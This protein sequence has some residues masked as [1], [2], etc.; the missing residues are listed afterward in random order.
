MDGEDDPIELWNAARRGDTDH[1]LELLHTH[2]GPGGGHGADPGYINYRSGIHGTTPL[3]CAIQ[4]GH[5]AATEHLIRHGADVSAVNDDGSTP[6][7][8]AIQ[9]APRIEFLFLLLENNPNPGDVNIKYKGE[10]PLS[11]AVANNS[12][13]SDISRQQ[14]AALLLHGA[15]V[16]AVD[17]SGNSVLHQSGIT[18]WSLQTFTALGVNIDIR[19]AGGRTPMQGIVYKSRRVGLRVDRITAWHYAKRV[20]MFLNAGADIDIKDGSGRTA[21]ELALD[22]HAFGHPVCDVLRRARVVRESRLAFAW[23]SHHD[24]G[25]SPYLRQF[26]P[27]IVRMI[28]DPEY[29]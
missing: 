24:S 13:N 3:Y 12:N 5:L 7:H 11:M 20:E 10:P 16:H 29:I 23:G 15:D 6:L 27:G 9:H 14:V 21:E 4:G 1:C 25:A 26:D 17:N 19:G 8:A 22:I 2:G 18:T 28:L